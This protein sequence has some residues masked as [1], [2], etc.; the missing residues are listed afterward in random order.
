MHPKLVTPLS[1]FQ[2]S[3]YIAL[4]LAIITGGV[5]LN[6]NGFGPK[7]LASVSCL[8][9]N[10][11]DQLIADKASLESQAAS[12]QAE[13]EQIQGGVVSGAESFVSNTIRIAELQSQILSDYAIYLEEQNLNQ[14]CSQSSN[15][16]VAGDCASI[17]DSSSCINASCLWGGDTSES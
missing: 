2:I 6:S 14:I 11:L 10:E 1:P 16:V 13:I 12:I 5:F 7:H 17:T 9:P 3:L 8:F 15:T 4:T